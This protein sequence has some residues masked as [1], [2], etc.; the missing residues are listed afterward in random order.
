MLIGGSV[1]KG[2]A[3]QLAFVEAAV[4]PLHHECDGLGALD[5]VIDRNDT[6]LDDVAMRF[7]HSFDFARENIFAAAHKHV[8]GSAEEKV[9]AVFVATKYV[10]ADVVAVLGNGR[11]DIGARSEE[12]RVGKECRCRWGT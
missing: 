9:K 11:G 3:F 4:L 6:G 8:V 7:Q 12:R 5:F 1:L 2:E 10:S